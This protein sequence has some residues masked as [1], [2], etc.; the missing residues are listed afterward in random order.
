MTATN[1]PHSI[2]ADYG[3]HQQDDSDIS[4]SFVNE[5]LGALTDSVLGCLV[6]QIMKLDHLSRAGAAQL[7]VDID[8]LRFLSNVTRR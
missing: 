2:L 7:C 4:A 6:V 3:S 1:S 8:Y 5:W